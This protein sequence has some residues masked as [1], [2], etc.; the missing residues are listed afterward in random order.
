[1]PTFSS[2][3]TYG[4]EAK[5][6]GQSHVAVWLGVVSPRPVGGVLNTDFL[7]KGI[8]IPAGTP[9]NLK[10]KVITP[11]VAFKVLAYSAA[12][13][14]DTYDEVTI[15][16]NTDFGVEIL[17]AAEDMLQKL[18]D[19][20]AT[21]AKAAEVHSV[22]ALTGDDAGKYKIEVAKSANLGSLTAGNY[23]V[24]SASATA[25]SSKAMANQPNG[26]LYN[27]IYLGN[28]E[29]DSDAITAKT[30]AAT[31]AVVDFH[32]EGILVDLTPAA[33]FKAAM[34]AA[35]PSVIQVEV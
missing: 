32:G 11:L 6:I 7:K 20:F 30:I 34:K 19:T 29:V 27:D 3:N 25:G 14:S 31:G 35:V 21:T 26:Y 17:P 12:G 28:L 13:E 1:M 16:P 23:L 4:S 22:T 5:N 2:F 8:L 9:V 33:P 18:G 15:A 24:F 10:E